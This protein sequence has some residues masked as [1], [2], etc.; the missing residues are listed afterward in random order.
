VK[1]R[2]SGTGLAFLSSI[3]TMGDGLLNP[4]PKEHGARNS[5]QNQA[6]RALL[7]QFEYDWYIRAKFVVGNL[8]GA[9][10]VAAM[11]KMEND[12][13]CLLGGS[14]LDRSSYLAQQ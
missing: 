1:Q 7:E 5:D 3:A 6:S 4:D 8:R 12:V 14:F 10:R 13:V 2:L 11:A 9:D